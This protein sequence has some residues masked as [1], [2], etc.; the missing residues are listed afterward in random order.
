MFLLPELSAEHEYLKSLSQQQRRRVRCV[1]E[2]MARSLPLILNPSEWVRCH[3][4]AAS[5]VAFSASLVLGLGIRRRL[6]GA[7][8][9]RKVQPRSEREGLQPRS[10]SRELVRSLVGGVRLIVRAGKLL[11]PGVLKNSGSS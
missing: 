4:Y 11:N 8:S 9:G 7:T 1:I 10:W 5:G 6:R 3:P 2:E